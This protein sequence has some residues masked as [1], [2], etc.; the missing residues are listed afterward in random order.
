MFGEKEKTWEKT[1][2]TLNKFMN[3]YQECEFLIDKENERKK[4]KQSKTKTRNSKKRKIICFIFALLILLN[5][6]S[7]FFWGRHFITVLN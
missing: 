5:S 1:F 7:R 2:E 3:E 6:L 4:T